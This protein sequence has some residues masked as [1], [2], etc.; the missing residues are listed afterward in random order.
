M[1]VLLQLRS[2]VNVLL[3]S[4]KSHVISNV[5]TCVRTKMLILRMFCILAVN[6]T[7]LHLDPHVKSSHTMPK[8]NELVSLSCEEGYLGKPVNI[9][10]DI[11]GNWPSE[12]P[13][14]AGKVKFS[15][16]VNYKNSI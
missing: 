2:E 7:N 13:N 1:S 16:K 3:Y 5:A 15:R 14:C 8:F 12:R 6:C 10:C 9:K 4:S 11:H